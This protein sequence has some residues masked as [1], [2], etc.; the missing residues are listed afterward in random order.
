LRIRS[1]GA[2]IAAAYLVFSGRPVFYAA[3][4]RCVMDEVVT[5]TQSGTLE[6]VATK[7]HRTLRFASGSEVLTVFSWHPTDQIRICPTDIGG[8]YTVT[9]LDTHLVGG[10]AH[11]TLVS[12]PPQP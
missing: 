11:G 7:A 9:N 2:A 8:L 10:A 3:E 5:V 1:L 4:S 12:G 6:L